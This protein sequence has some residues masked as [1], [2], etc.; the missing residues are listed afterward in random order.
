MTGTVVSVT[1]LGLPSHYRPH[2]SALVWKKPPRDWREQLRSIIENATTSSTSQIF[3]RADDIG[4]GGCAFDALCRL[5]RHHQIPLAMAVV[6][7][8]LTEVRT[9]QLF[10]VAPL[11]ESLWGWHQHGWRHINWED[12]GHKSEFGNQRPFEK[13]WHDLC[14]G[15]KKMA[16]I[17]G[18]HFIRVFTPPWNRLSS[19]TLRIL[20][21]LDFKG[22]STDGPLPGLIKPV[23]NLRNL[24][25][26]LD[27]HTRKSNDAELDFKIM[28]KQL[29]D[30]LSRTEPSGIMLHHQR[31]TH[32]AFEFLNE[33]IQLLKMSGKVRFLGFPELLEGGYGN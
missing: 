10:E 6:P 4:A 25:I 21:E 15:S 23:I 20:Q 1:D 19:K 17:F 2:Q 30:V 14:Q 27:L 11:D 3:F 32:F 5:F 13:Q 28:L 7:S 26:F 9:R 22:V 31:M 16:G 18:L 8:W 12:T 24:R 33:L 29:S